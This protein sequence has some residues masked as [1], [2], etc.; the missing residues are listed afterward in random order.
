M[1]NHVE[2]FSSPDMTPTHTSG[3]TAHRSPPS[4]GQTDPFYTQGELI[5]PDTQ[6]DDTWVTVFGYVYISDFAFVCSIVQILVENL[7]NQL[8]A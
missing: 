2:F 6:L 1:Q 3:F 5:T 8:R 4:P 7:L